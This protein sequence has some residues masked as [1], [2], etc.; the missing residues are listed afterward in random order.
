MGD[1]VAGDA[2]VVA[3]DGPVAA[4]KTT[5]G[6]LLSKRI[7]ALFFDTGVLYRALAMRVLKAGVNPED[8][9][10]VASITCRMN[11]SLRYPASR[12]DRAADVYLDG[13]D[14]TDCLRSPEIDRTLPGVSANPDVRKSLLKMQRDIAHGK[15]VVVVGRDIG[16]VIFPDAAFKYFIEAT[17]EVRARRRYLELR[18][19]GEAVSYEDV[20]RDLETRDERD[21]SRSD[22]PLLIADGAVVLDATQ[23]SAEEIADRIAAEIAGKNGQGDS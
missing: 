7:D 19:R 9:T 20:L 12:S 8:R 22:A 16:S 10:A 14:V 13:R 18:E 1:L 6:K 5:V 11:V 17:P 23:N 3:I 4:G 15:R 21:L 2:F